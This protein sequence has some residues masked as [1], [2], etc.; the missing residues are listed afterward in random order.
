MH[1]IYFE[2]QFGENWFTYADLYTTL[3]KISAE[4]S[5]FV[6]VGSWK[7]KSSSYMCVEIINSGKKI[8]FY[9]VDTWLDSEEHKDSPDLNYLYDIFKSNMMPVEG[10]FNE[11]RMSS[12][13][14]CAMFEDNSLDFVFLDA[15]HS[16]SAIRND[17]LNWFPKVKVGGILAGHDYY[18]HENN[19]VYR[20]VVDTFSEGIP[21]I[22][23]CFVIKKIF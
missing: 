16:Y 14:A 19:S 1:H 4:N 13:E 3:V 20:A 8:D 22:D 2:P 18:P 11:I 21:P 7:G 23:D 9:C 5:K 12:L 10:Y 6:E 17:I 15:D